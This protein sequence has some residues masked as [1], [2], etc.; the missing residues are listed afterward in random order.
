MFDTSFQFNA[1]PHIVPVAP[2]P[3]GPVAPVA[4][5]GTG[6]IYGGS[7]ASK[8]V[9]NLGLP[10]RSVATHITSTTNAGLSGRIITLVT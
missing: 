1:C 7:A 10:V 3:E 9:V 8:Y 6:N 2:I 5:K 4:P